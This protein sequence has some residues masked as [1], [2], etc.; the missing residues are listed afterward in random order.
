[1]NH[2]PSGEVQNAHGFQPAALA[3]DPVTQGVID[4]SGPQQAEEQK[5]LELDP[6]HEGAGNQSR[7]NDGKHHL[8]SGKQP[9][10]DGF[11]VIVVGLGADSQ[12]A[13]K[14]KPPDQP[15]DI[16]AKGEG[17]AENDP[18]QTDERQKYVTEGQRGK[19]I[20]SADHPPVKKGEGRR[21]QQHQGATNQ[22][23]GRIAGIDRTEHHKP[24]SV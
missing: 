14:I 20:F 15:V 23:P 5:A 13:D 8:K 2:R 21:H 19:N 18:L 7:G 1:M 4:Q 12:K 10:G 17:I 24:P 16:R 9:V 22:D 11:A 3:P 6:L